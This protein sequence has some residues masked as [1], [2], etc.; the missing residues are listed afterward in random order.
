MSEIRTQLK[1]VESKRVTI[2]TDYKSR[3]EG[4]LKER[5]QELRDDYDI[6]GKRFKEETQ[7]LYSSK[8]TPKRDS[9]IIQSKSSI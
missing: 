7:L 2:E 5:L 1:T 9:A 6:E 8:V 4:A 3:Y